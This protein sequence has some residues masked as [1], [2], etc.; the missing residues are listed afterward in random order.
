MLSQDWPVTMSGAIAFLL[1]LHTLRQHA[2]HCEPEEVLCAVRLSAHLTA[3]VKLQNTNN[4]G[5]PVS[6]AASRVSLV[7][8]YLWEAE[9]SGTLT[10]LLAHT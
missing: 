2:V 10:C 9:E 7:L 5:V 4:D 1:K 8:C 3:V 6:T